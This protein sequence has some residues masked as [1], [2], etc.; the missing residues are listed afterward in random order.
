MRPIESLKAAECEE[1][2]RKL[3]NTYVGLKRRPFV[4]ARTGTTSKPR[5]LLCPADARDVSLVISAYARTHT[6]PLHIQQGD[7]LA[8]MDPFLLTE[9]EPRSGEAMGLPAEGRGEV[10]ASKQTVSAGPRPNQILRVQYPQYEQSGP[11]NSLKRPPAH[12]EMNGN[13]EE[14]LRKELKVKIE[15]LSSVPRLLHIRFDY[16]MPLEC[17]LNSNIIN[18]V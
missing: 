2:P 1:S 5:V 12:M 4:G 15:H 3:A 18:P 6:S 13:I 8:K 16:T 17:V 9:E 14:T 7:A 11:S 10:W